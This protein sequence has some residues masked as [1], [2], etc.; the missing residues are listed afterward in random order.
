M[1]RLKIVLVE[2]NDHGDPIR[3]FDNS[4]AARL[5]PVENVREWDRTNAVHLIRE[6]IFRRSKGDCEWCGRFVTRDSG[7]MHE[8]HARGKRD[9]NG[10]YGEISISNSVFICHNCHTGPNGAHGDR[11]WGGRDGVNHGIANQR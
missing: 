3:I 8:V 9:I 1:K 10:N 7:E 2:I 11:K 6:A 5:H 4:K